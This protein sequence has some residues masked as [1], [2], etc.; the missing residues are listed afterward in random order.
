MSNKCAK[1]I[2]NYDGRVRTTIDDSCFIKE[3]NLCI[4]HSKI[5][6]KDVSNF[7]KDLNDLIVK[8]NNSKKPTKTWNCYLFDDIEF[9]NDF[10]FSNFCEKNEFKNMKLKFNNCKLENLYLKNNEIEN[11]V[12]FKNCEIKN[13]K[14]EN[15]EF[16]NTIIFD[17][18]N[19][20]KLD[21]DFVEFNEEL[22]FLNVTINEEFD[23]TKTVFYKQKNFYGINVKKV[24][25]RE[26]AR[27]IKDSFEQQNNIIEANKFYA[28]EMKEREN[29]LKWEKDFFEKLVFSFHGWSSNHSQDWILSL[30]W[31]VYFTFSI[32]ML[33]NNQNLNTVIPVITVLGL[34]II[35][36]SNSDTMIRSVLLF[37]L[38]IS[39]YV[40]YFAITKDCSLHYFANKLNPF[41]IMNG[42][43]DLNFSNF[44]YK[45]V[46]AYLIYQ[47]IISIRQNTRRK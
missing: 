40:L 31:I 12:E 27:I 26:T 45:V 4:L 46:I 17:N 21:F 42:W 13:L 39:N 44:I 6:D 35:I 9:P 2:E 43:D 41:S 33:E 25:N 7:S 22:F 5:K 1:C 37:V 11:I 30:F 20:T 15:V 32:L 29:E 34:G 28:L 16:D 19:I 47:L 36:S 3:D 38:A 10:E 14:L 18:V 24:K 23:L 8:I